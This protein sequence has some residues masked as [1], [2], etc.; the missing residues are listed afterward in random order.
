MGILHVFDM[1][2]TLLRGTTASL[3]V[4]RQLGN[5]AELIALETQFSTGEIDAIGYAA[6]VHAL[7]QG[8][9]AEPVA[10]AFAASPWVGG[11][12]EVCA[13]IRRRGER[14]V[15]ITLS[16]DFFATLLLERGFDE[17]VASRFP[18]LP[19]T[20]P[21]DPSGLLAPADKV[22]VVDELL[23]RYGIPRSR[24]V[25]YGDSMSDAPLFRHLDATV[26]VNADHHLIGIA[27]ASYQGDD[28]TE[29]YALGR[30]LLLPRPRAAE[31]GADSRAGAAGPDS[32]TGVL[33]AG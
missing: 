16:P 13:D 7:W 6:T 22:T 3:Q 28:L 17:V 8:L 4:A 25:A 14:S 15:V 19:S 11:I 30:S 33:P 32:G 29:A 23:A 31:A 27:A 24:C 1:D 20:A 5:V 18:P 12:D 10:A 9:T 21:L 26:A 2:G